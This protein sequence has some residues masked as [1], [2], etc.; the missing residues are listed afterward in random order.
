MVQDKIGLESGIRKVRNLFTGDHFGEISLIYNCRR[1][2]TVVANNYTTL[3]RLCP[4]SFK[5]IASN[6]PPYLRHLK[7]Q[8]YHYDDPIKLFLEE[9]LKKIH[10]MQRLDADAFHDVLF[11]F[12]QE[13]CE[14]GTY[15]FKEGET[16]SGV[17]IV[18]SGIIEISV[19]VEG[20]ALAI[21]RLY[22][23]SIINPNA[24]LIGDFCDVSGRCIDTLTMFYLTYQQIENIRLK[25]PELGIEIDKVKKSA[26]FKSIP[27]I[28]D[29]IM[30]K[31]VLSSRRGLEMDERRAM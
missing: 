26:A 31:S 10:Y 24:F 18:K 4:Q 14:S 27:Y 12:Q 1:S 11:N 7:D 17:F 2:A 29:Y 6:F 30:G 22:R 28:V 21:E 23:G 8:V 20:A 15:L 19:T 3:A 13:T 9:Y 16:S 5:D 25:H